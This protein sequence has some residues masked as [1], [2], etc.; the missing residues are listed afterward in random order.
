MPKQR[1]ELPEPRASLVDVSR[2]VPCRSLAQSPSWAS[3]WHAECLR[4]A[5]RVRLHGTAKPCRGGAVWVRFGHGQARALLI[6]WW[7]CSRFPMSDAAVTCMALCLAPCRWPHRQRA[8]PQRDGERH[9]KK[10]KKKGIVF[11]NEAYVRARNRSVDPSGTFHQRHTAP[12]MQ[13]GCA[14]V[15]QEQLET[16][17]NRKCEVTF[18]LRKKKTKGSEF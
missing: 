2:P 5:L 15:L 3:G 17:E 11:P 8:Q 16:I 4:G 13:W 7:S 9:Q 12:V 14:V 1:L 18:S 6:Q 10:K